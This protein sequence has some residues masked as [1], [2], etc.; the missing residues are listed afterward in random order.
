MIG[1]ATNVLVRYMAQDE[2]KQ[3]AIATRLIERQLSPSDPGF[4]SL[5]VL[6][7]VSTVG[8]YSSALTAQ[9]QS[10]SCY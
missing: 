2:P 9:A 5:V 7:F 4:V 3:S 6:D 1:L 10:N 8:W